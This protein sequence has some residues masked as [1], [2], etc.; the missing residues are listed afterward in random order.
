MEI[1]SC[2]SYAARPAGTRLWR[3]G[4][5]AFKVY[6]VDIYGRDHPE[7]F[8]WDLNELNQ[9]AVPQALDAM[10]LEGVGF[11][12][13]FP[14]IVKI[15][16]YAPSAEILIFVKA[17]KPG[18]GSPI[19]LDRGDGYVEFAC[20]AEAVIGAEEYKLWAGA[21]SV[22]TYLDEWVEWGELPIVDHT[23]LSRYWGS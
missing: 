20:L 1:T 22:E 16:R 12:I 6:Y 23:K 10:G 2:N 5:S 8:E 3:S 21:P 19:D 11:V 4:K 7:R 18:D 13:A 9:D 17:F 15:F 14:H